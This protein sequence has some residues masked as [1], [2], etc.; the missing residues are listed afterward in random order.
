MIGSREDLRDF[1][2]DSKCETTILKFTAEWCGPCK[3]TKPLLAKLNTHYKE[4]GADYQYI[5]VDVDESMDLYAFLKKTKMVNGIPT[6]LVYKKSMFNPET[7]YVPF[8][9]I[10]G[11]NEQGII[12][13][14]KQSLGN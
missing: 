14:F 6:I 10:S 8:A 7:Y 9:G 2:R 11:A 13:V 4:K 3:A 1:L 5:E 12:N